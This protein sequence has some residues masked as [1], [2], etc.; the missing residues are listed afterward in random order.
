MV[1]AESKPPP[2][3]PLVGYIRARQYRALGQEEDAI[4]TLAPVLARA[5][6]FAEALALQLELLIG[7]GHYEEV[8]RLLAPRL[9]EDPNNL[10]LLVTLAEVN[11]GLGNHYDAIR[12]FERARIR[13]REETPDLLNKLAAEYFADDQVEKARALFERSL[14]LQ[15][16]QPEIRRLLEKMQE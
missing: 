12:Y 5:P 16:E 8:D 3:D 11:A 13:S 9:I 4:A 1:Q 15:P 10:E 14:Q 7:A 6:D 2:T